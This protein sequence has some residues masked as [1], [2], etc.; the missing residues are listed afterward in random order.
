[1]VTQQTLDKNTLGVVFYFVSKLNGILGKTHLQKLLFLT[2]LIA[3]KKLKE[4]ITTIEY[5]K[6]KHGPY[7]AEID[8][9]TNHLIDL[10]YIESKEFPLSSNNAKKY[11]RYYL[12]KNIPIKEKLLKS[13]GSKKLLVVDEIADSFGNLSLQNLLDIVYNLPIVKNSKMDSLLDIIKD[14]EAESE[15]EKNALSDLPF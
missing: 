3:M 12:K 15:E 6:Y 4:K 2:D 10:N 7:S 13:L 14:I 5:K 1:M 9:Y 8:D 11:T